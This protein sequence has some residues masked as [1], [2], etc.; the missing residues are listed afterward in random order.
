[1]SK[2]IC[3]IL[4]LDGFFIENTFRVC[5]LGYYTWKEQ[6]GR[7]AFYMPTR[8]TDLN[9][10]DKQTVTYVNRQV[11]GLS[12]Y[13]NQGEEGYSQDEVNDIVNHLYLSCKTDEKYVVAYK[14]GHGERNVLDSINVE[15]FNLEHWRCPKFDIVKDTVVEL[16][17]PF[18]FHPPPC[19]SHD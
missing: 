15:S 19:Q 1:M 17:P 11:N 8:W 7:I 4:A 12:Y 10:K 9:D 5:E 13:L 18:H 2:H 6:F 3:M 14:G 16:L